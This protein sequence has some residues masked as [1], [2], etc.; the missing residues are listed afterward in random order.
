MED[1]KNQEENGAAPSQ[2]IW[3]PRFNFKKLSMESR[4]QVITQHREE[5][6]SFG[7]LFKA[8]AK[9]ST[10]SYPAAQVG[11]FFII[12]KLFSYT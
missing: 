9:G 4:V 10:I 3:S 7:K 1:I 11:I 12:C 2:V 6:G 8:Q 5:L